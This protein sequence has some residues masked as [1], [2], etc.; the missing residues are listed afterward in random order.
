MEAPW[1]LD[2]DRAGWLDGFE[3]VVTAETENTRPG[4]RRS[5]GLFFPGATSGTSL[6][7]LL[8]SSAA[9]SSSSGS[10]MSSGHAADRHS[11]DGV[12]GLSV[13]FVASS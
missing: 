12:V 3:M 9:G 4:G 8:L 10:G 13:E 2:D 1:P 7:E 6:G 11:S 5:A